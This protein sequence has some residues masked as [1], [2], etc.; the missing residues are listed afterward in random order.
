MQSERITALSLSKSSARD[1]QPYDVGFQIFSGILEPSLWTWVNAARH[2]GNCHRLPSSTINTS[3]CF[4]WSLAELGTFERCCT[5]GKYKCIFFLGGFWSC[6]WR[7]QH[8]GARTRCA[9]GEVLAC[10]LYAGPCVG[11]HY[12]RSIQ[13]P[14]NANRARPLVSI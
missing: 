2:A 9:N 11:H 6:F 14:A 7:P 10:R 1:L 13:V 5:D 4:E 3:S 8:R 12:W